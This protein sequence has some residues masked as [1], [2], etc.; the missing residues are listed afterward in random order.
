MKEMR[1][2]FGKRGLRF[3]GLA[4]LAAIV[5]GASARVLRAE[6]SDILTLNQFGS[7]LGLNEA[8]ERALKNQAEVKRA[9]ARLKMEEALYKGSIA[10]FL[11][12]L[13]G[14][15]F[16]AAATGQKKSVTYLDAGV[17]QPLF[18]GGKILAGKRKHKAR[19]QSEE[20][21]LEETRL[22]VELAVMILYAQVLK[23][24]ELTRI[25]QGQVKEL[26]LE[27]E[28]IKR[29][30]D[31]EILPR[32]DFFRIETLLQSA[33]HAL[34]KH[35]ET[36]DYLFGVLRET[37]GV[38]EDESLDLQTL[39]DFP[40]LEQEISGYLEIARKHDPIYRLSEL[41]VKEKTFEKRELQADR[42]PHVS[43]AAKWNRF[44]DVF[45][46]TDR[47]MVGIKG[48]W[49]IW[50]FG[51]LGNQIK[52]KSYEIEESKWAGEIEIREHEKE[53]RKF[54]HE[55]RA[56]RQKIRLAEALVQER[57]EI[58]KNEKTKLIA[59]EKGSGELVDSFIALEEAKI[60]QIEAVTQYRI[61]AARLDRKT[62]FQAMPHDNGE[63]HEEDY[64][65]NETEVEE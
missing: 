19:V 13:S 3:V 60:R 12:R 16:Q 64:A 44:N 49:N 35:K 61:L 63:D 43:L 25:A 22:D 51:R 11:P 14:E 45:V 28:R 32:Y 54:F 15:I 39:S 6:Q 65:V 56:A 42:F 8:V 34:V 41:K 1:V 2:I 24:R 31:K 21:K 29:L 27:H 20:V 50:D 18:Q 9:F 55:A 37:V 62:A 36:Y 4:L 33:K 7:L 5:A 59:G 52:A 47:A 53:I 48:T 38:K 23:E 46:D 10:E 57:T 40:E 26:T 30:V 17:E 58:F